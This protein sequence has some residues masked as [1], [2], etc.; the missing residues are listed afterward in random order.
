MVKCYTGQQ[1]VALFGIAFFCALCSRAKPYATIGRLRCRGVQYTTSCFLQPSCPMCHHS[2]TTQ[3]LVCRPY[4]ARLK[5]RLIAALVRYLGCCV[6]TMSHL[7]VFTHAC[8]SCPCPRD[9][10]VFGCFCERAGDPVSLR[11]FAEQAI[12][13]SPIVSRLLSD[14][15]RFVLYPSHC[16]DLRC[17]AVPLP[18]NVWALSILETMNTSLGRLIEAADENDS[19]NRDNKV[20]RSEKVNCHAKPLSLRCFVSGY[21][22]R[23]GRNATTSP[24]LLNHQMYSPGT[25]NTALRPIYYIALYEVYCTCAFNR[26]VRCELRRRYHIIANTQT[27]PRL[28]NNAPIT[29]A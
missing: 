10:P 27:L 11:G 5:T 16:P 17:R 12:Y 24:Q 19:R 22:H 4:L 28:L 25:Q 6:S 21:R 2:S 29:R 1:N 14:L 9:A 18:M 26:A 13:I 7:M 15:A 8:C 23:R 3:L 20:A